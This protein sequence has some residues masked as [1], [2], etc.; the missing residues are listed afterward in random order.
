M[1]S[2]TKSER[3]TSKTKNC[4]KLCSNSNTICRNSNMTCRSTATTCKSIKNWKRRIEPAQSKSFC[5]FSVLLPQFAHRDVL[6][7][8]Y[9]DVVSADQLYQMPV[10]MTAHNPNAMQNAMQLAMYH[11]GL[12]STSSAMLM[13][14]SIQATTSGSSNQ[15]STFTSN[16]GGT[17]Q[18][19]SSADTSSSHSSRQLFQSSEDPNASGGPNF[20]TMYERYPYLF[21][22]Q[23]M[24][25]SSII[26]NNYIAWMASGNSPMLMPTN[27]TAAQPNVSYSQNLFL[28]QSQPQPNANINSAN[29]NLSYVNASNNV[30]LDM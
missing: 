10:D 11:Q 25:Q 2:Q 14:D 18:C 5:S 15:S 20:Q 13:N 22:H 27:D 19:H 21:Q 23:T 9:A 7:Y 4:K 28:Q 8:R 12:P 16:A 1:I 3:K 17:T 29:V 6:N 26:Q 24:N 30:F